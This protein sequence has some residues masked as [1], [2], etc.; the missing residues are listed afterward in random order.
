MI[1]LYAVALGLAAGLARAK[2]KGRPFQ[3][4]PP[5]QIGL[6]FTATL[7]QAMALYFPPTRKAMPDWLV[8][9]FLVGTQICLL[10]FIWLNRTQPGFPILGAG[11]ALNILVIVANGGWMPVSPQVAAE[12]FPG[13]ALTPGMRVGWS[14]D[15][16]LF[17]S[18]THLWCLSDC[19][20]LPDWLPQR[21]AFSLGDILIAAGVFWALWVRGGPAT[22]TGD[23]PNPGQHLILAGRKMIVNLLRGHA[24]RQTVPDATPHLDYTSLQPEDLDFLQNLPDLSSEPEFRDTSRPQPPEQEPQ[25]LH[26]KYKENATPPKHIQF[27]GMWDWQ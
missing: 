4:N 15:I 13:A 20:L 10:I 22:G 19:L 12:L 21:A 2:S 14:K 3:L 17:P 23:N 8:V 6:L 7:I 18:E 5:G 11:L 27:K 24:T 16:L 9:L 1:L 25:Q 26:G